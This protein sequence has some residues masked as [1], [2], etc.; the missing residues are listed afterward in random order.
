MKLPIATTS[1]LPD[2]K[3][4]ATEPYTSPK[5]NTYSE[6]EIIELIGPA[7]TCGSETLGTPPFGNAYGY[8]HGRGRKH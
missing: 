8:R 6:H 2:K 4:K 7:T 5:I 1:V 3:N